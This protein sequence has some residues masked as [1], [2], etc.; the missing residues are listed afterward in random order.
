[1]A[2]DKFLIAPFSS[3][4]QT[5]VRPF[6]IPDDAFAEM[7]NAYVFRGRV[8]KRFGSQLMGSSSVKATA[9]LLSRLRVQ[10]GTIGAPSSP[11]PGTIYEI[12]QMFSA[13]TQVFTVYQTGTPAA[14]LAVDLITGATIGTGTFNT[15]TGAFVLAGTGLAAGTPI[16]WYPAQPV[17]GLTT[18]AKANTPINDQPIIAF[19]T[20]FAYT[21]NNGWTRVG[22]GTLPIWQ[23]DDLNFFWTTNWKGA[24]PDDQ[25]LFVSNFNAT[26]GTP[27]L[28]DDPMYFY[29]STLATTWNNFSNYTVFKTDGSYV[30]SA[31]LIVPF[32]N[33][34]IL[35]NTIERLN[36]S[37]S[38]LNFAYPNRMRWSIIGSPIAQEV[39]TVGPDTARAPYAYLEPNQ[40]W[41]VT[42]GAATATG[43][44]AGGG[45]LDAATDEAI[46]SI[47]FIKDRL[48]VFFERSTWE[49]I[50]TGNYSA[51]FYWQKIN[52]ELG[53]QATFSPVPFDKQVITVGNTGV[54]ACNGA[55]VERIDD[56]IPN[57]IFNIRNKDQSVQRTAGIRDYYAEMVYWTYV[58]RDLQS[59]QTYPDKV[60]VYNYKNNTWSINDDSFTAFGYW[61]QSTDITWASTPL[62][63]EECTF[64]WDENL[65][66]ANSRQIVAGNM[67][68][69]VLVISPDANRNAA[70][71]Q[72][73]NM[74]YDGTTGLVTLIIKDHTLSPADDDG[75]GDF[76]YI[77]SAKGVSFVSSNT[78]FPV[79]SVVDADTITISAV[80]TGTYLGGGTAARVS[81]IWIL[82][83]QWNPYDKQARDV[84]LN[85]IDFFV[86]STTQAELTVDYFPSSSNLSM[87]Q[88]GGSS[89]TNV[90]IGNNVLEM[91]PYDPASIEG[92]QTRIWKPVYFLGEGQSIQ[93]L[94]YLSDDQATN[95][96]SALAPFELDAMVLYLR[97]TTHRFQ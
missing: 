90:N 69:F 19:D 47:E 53:S 17:M 29:D 91:F 11:V 28:T 16:Y 61:E 58:S 40:T 56:K 31:K 50:W 30:Q 72:I 54:H 46:V 62:T 49:V 73:T 80:M 18:Y 57:Q 9:P 88:A 60:L 7:Y 85:K 83:K 89:G 1:M 51:P 71:L 12:G 74:T 65:Q 13:G 68:G 25:A 26:V 4:L 87:V 39:V 2:M 36:P 15:T 86:K 5:D 35:F 22:A 32:K 84:N 75:N 94:I 64:T 48:I 77:E 66:Q 37:G 33:S 82:S 34:L 76:I 42:V 21:Y 43:K 8:R 70:S 95:P 3:G 52:T 67:E 27:S 96:A 23:G 38:N 97:P 44:A 93:I 55:N 24:D 78:I 14:M 6:L 20:Q 59:S 10:V 79:N 63:W 81:K 45:Y 41:S 92:T